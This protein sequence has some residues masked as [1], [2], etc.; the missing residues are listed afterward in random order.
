MP[1]PMTTLVTNAIGLI[2]AEKELGVLLLAITRGAV[3]QNW[4]QAPASDPQRLQPEARLAQAGLIVRNG[5][6]SWVLTDLGQQVSIYL[7]QHEADEELALMYGRLEFTADSVFLDLGCGAGPALLKACELPTSPRLLVGVDIDR[8]SLM[9]A[10]AFLGTHRRRCLL[11][12]ADLAALPIKTAAVSHLCSR[13]SL[14][15]VDQ[16]ASMAELGRVLTPGGNAFLQLHAP[17]FYLQLLRDDLGNWKRVVFNSFCLVNG[18]L[19]SFLGIQLRI[20]RR[21]GVYQEL[22]QTHGGMTRVLKRQGIAV[23]WSESDHLFRIF[24]RKQRV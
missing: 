19:F 11:V 15:Y 2:R 7:S 10:N 4:Q 8:P 18:F 12:Q 13:L 16:H 14:P 20:S 24:G 17:R 21:T 23:L 1:L 6:D 22:Y 3:S 5:S 9:A